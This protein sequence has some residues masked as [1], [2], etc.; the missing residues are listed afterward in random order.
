VGAAVGVAVGEVGEV[1]GTAVG[2]S[3]ATHVCTSQAEHPE[4]RW[5][6]GKHWH[7]KVFP[8]PCPQY[9]DARSQLWVPPVQG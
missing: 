8:C 2:E 4:N 6:P 5:N 3:V 7:V 1:V 9:V